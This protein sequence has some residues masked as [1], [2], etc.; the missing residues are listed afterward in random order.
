MNYNMLD[1]WFHFDV[2]EG[3]FYAAFGF[4]FVFLGIV[5]LIILFT[6]LGKI[7]KEVNKPRKPRSKRRGGKKSKADSPETETAQGPTQEGVT[8]E[9]IAVISAAIAAY[10]ENENVKCD[11]VVKRIKK[12]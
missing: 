8:P 5:V 7:M 1:G 10:Y 3:A 4:L 11:F 12:L 6:A 9:L 2:G